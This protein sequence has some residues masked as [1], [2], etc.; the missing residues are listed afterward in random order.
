M[1][2]LL[3]V[4]D[5]NGINPA[6]HLDAFKE[7]S[8]SSKEFQGHGW[9]CAW[10]DCSSQ[11]QLHHN[12]L[13][14]WEDQNSFPDTT[15]FLAHAR[16]AF[17]DEGIVVENNMPFTDGTNIFLFNGELQGVKIRVDGRI[18]AEKIFNTIRRFDKGDLVEATRRAV[19][20]INKR[21]RYIRA[22]NFFLASRDQI[23]V[24]SQFGE[25]PEY[26]QINSLRAGDTRIICSQPYSFS[27]HPWEKIENKQLETIELN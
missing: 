23:L 18:G 22:M 20:V 3:L 26:F 12:I 21:T 1:C 16:S 27:D 15:L 25:S 19:G 4:S 8:R 24:Y 14:V 5:Q 2:R 6:S 13:P 10:L 17:R 9:G 7:I 11:W